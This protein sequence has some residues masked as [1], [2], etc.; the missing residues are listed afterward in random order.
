M[1]HMV[2]LSPLLETTTQPW[3]LVPLR[4]LLTGPSFR[5]THRS[6]RSPSPACASARRT[7][8]S[9]PSEKRRRER[10]GRKQ[11]VGGLDKSPA[12]MDREPNDRESVGQ[13]PP[14]RAR[15]PHGR[16]G[17]RSY[18]DYQGARNGHFLTPRLLLVQYT[19]S[20]RFLNS[21]GAHPL[22]Q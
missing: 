11:K 8:P 3:D 15:V 17:E 18:P 6:S 12:S 10:E 21:L 9:A 16:E 22:M 7:R 19:D 14:P 20:V 2:M 13:S 4:L 1:A 5:T